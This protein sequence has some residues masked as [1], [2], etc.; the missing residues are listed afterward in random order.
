M[1]ASHLCRNSVPLNQG[2]LGFLDAKPFPANL[3]VEV[4]KISVISYSEIVVDGLYF[5]FCT[6]P[7]LKGLAK[8]A[9][10]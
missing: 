4:A 3:S 1:D 5:A 6:L 9:V 7:T 10:K 8:P 2:F